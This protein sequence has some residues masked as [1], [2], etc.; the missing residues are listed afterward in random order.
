[1][2]NEQDDRAPGGGHRWSGQLAEP[3]DVP[4]AL[5]RATDDVSVG[6][7]CCLVRWGSSRRV[8]SGCDRPSRSLR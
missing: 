4:D 3:L 6:H 7:G 2:L 5:F 1:M 8:G